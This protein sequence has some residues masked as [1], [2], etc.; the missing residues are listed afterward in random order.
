MELTQLGPQISPYHP[1]LS[2]SIKIYLNYLRLTLVLQSMHQ[3][4]LDN[5]YVLVLLITTCK[6]ASFYTKTLLSSLECFSET[7]A[8]ERETKHWNIL[9]FFV[10]LPFMPVV[11]CISK[12]FFVLHSVCV[13]LWNRNKMLLGNERN[14]VE[15]ELDLIRI[16]QFDCLLVDVICL[17]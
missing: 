7:L 1:I 9:S 11:F 15:M 10:V 14:L 12:S 3:N 16:I 5:E 8:R 2:R 6:A 17:K 4:E 13:G